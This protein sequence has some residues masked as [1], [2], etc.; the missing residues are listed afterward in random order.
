MRIRLLGKQWWVR[1]VNHLPFRDPKKLKCGDCSSPD[2]PDRVIRI[3]RNLQPFIELEAI[4]HEMLH[5]LDWHKDED[6]WVAPSAYEMTIAQWRLGY[7]RLDKDELAE[8]YKRR[9]VDRTEEREWLKGKT[10]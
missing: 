3:R 5:A 4:N 8:W 9:D 10:E 7:R 6:S 2:E 1:W